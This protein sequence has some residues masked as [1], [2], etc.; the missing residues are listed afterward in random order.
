MWRVL[1]LLPNVEP[2]LPLQNGYSM[3]VHLDFQ[4]LLFV[5]LRNHQGERLWFWLAKDSFPDRW[6]GF[7]CAVYSRSEAFPS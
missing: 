5:S 3:T 6:H 4:R 7:R 1:T 2:V